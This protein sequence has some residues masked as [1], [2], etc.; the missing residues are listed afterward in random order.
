[1]RRFSPLFCDHVGPIPPRRG[2]PLSGFEV[3]HI[4]ASVGGETSNPIVEEKIFGALKLRLDIQ[5]WI[6]GLDRH[7]ARQTDGRYIQLR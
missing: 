5:E 1:V 4:F 6:E 7:K 2:S 3:D